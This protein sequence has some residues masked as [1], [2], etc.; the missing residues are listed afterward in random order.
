MRPEMF[1]DNHSAWLSGLPPYEPLP[2]LR[3]PETADIA[4]IGGGITGVSTA[5]HLSERYPDRR[6]VLLEARA[7]AY[8]AS[9]RSGGQVLNGINGIE[10]R[11]AALAQRIFAATCAGIDIV[12][13]LSARSSVD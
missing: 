6:V 2:P 13:A 8:G 11:D 1:D 5:W 4:V 3:G 7:L 9:G 10:P 12:A